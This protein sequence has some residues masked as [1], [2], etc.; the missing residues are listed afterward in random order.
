MPFDAEYVGDA[1]LLPLRGP[2]RVPDGVNDGLSDAAAVEDLSALAVPRSDTVAAGEFVPRLD[3]LV[4]AVTEGE[5]APELEPLLDGDAAPVL[6]NSTDADSVPELEM[7]GDDVA[8][9]LILA[10]LED[11]DGDPLCERVRSALPVGDADVAP[12]LVPPGDAVN[13]AV[14]E[15][16]AVADRLA[17]LLALE[18]RESRGVSDGLFD[19]E[20]RALEDL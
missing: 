7:H 17:P 9:L 19:T 20:L 18:L 6:V 12:L 14:I 3:E 15:V 1:E 4:D 10:T 2:V 5:R 11:A 8:V 16:D 13:E